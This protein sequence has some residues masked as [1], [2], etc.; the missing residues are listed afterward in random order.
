MAIMTNT[1][2]WQK[3][4][5]CMDRDEMRELQLRRLRGTVRRCYD[6]VPHYRRAM[7]AKGVLPGDIHCVEDLCALPFTVKTDL[8]DNYPFDLFAAPMHQVVRVHA[9]SGTTGKPIVVGYTKH[10]IA[11]WAECIA[12]TLSAGGVTCS[13]IIQVAYGYGLFTGGLGLHYGAEEVGATVVPIS[14]GNTKRQISFLQ[15]FG[16][17]A[18]A[19]TPS[20]A[21]YMGETI[22][23]EGIPLESLKLRVGFFGA[24]PWSNA[25]R[26]DIEAKLGILALDIY[27]L[28]E[29]IGPGVAYE[30]PLQCGLH[31]AEDHFLPEIIDPE[32]EETLPPGAAGELVFT[33]ISKEAA[34]VLRYRTRD[35][36]RLHVDKC[37]C[38]RTAVRIER[39]MGRTDD[40]LIV[41]GVNVF[42]SQIESALM[43]LGYLEPHYLI[44][45]D[46]EAG[47]MDQIE[48]RV[49][50]SDTMFNDEVRAI[51]DLER[52]IHHEIS[53][54]LGISVKVRLVEPRSIPRSEGKAKRVVDRR[55]V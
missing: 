16:T 49:E 13:D 15:D 55:G 3:D 54:V 39:L 42:P 34:P 20:F 52:R 41:R 17:T 8:R 35:L 12:R 11:L 10:D 27:G 33:T 4:I 24:E 32:T 28:T 1:V 50:V 48:V 19:C 46:R 37:E 26:R 43:E 31:V 21:A 45:V 51:E 40:M 53:S 25:L 44:V 9:S 7:D 36:S 29:V 30:C 14:G 18:L 22:R 6:N 2:Y 23:D 47:H 5:E 38:G